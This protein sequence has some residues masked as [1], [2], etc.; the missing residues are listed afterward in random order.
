MAGKQLQTDYTNHQ[1]RFND[2]LN[3]RSGL[4]K[5]YLALSWQIQSF[6]YLARK[7]LVSNVFYP[8]SLRPD[9]MKNF[10]KESRRGYT[11]RTVQDLA[12]NFGITERSMEKILLEWESRLIPHTNVS[13]IKDFIIGFVKYYLAGKGVDF[14]EAEHVAEKVQ[15]YLY[16]WYDNEI[17]PAQ[18]N[19][20]FYDD[21]LPLGMYVEIIFP[22]E[23]FDK[24]GSVERYAKELLPVLKKRIVTSG[25][26]IYFEFGW[27]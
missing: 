3:Q 8:P 25:K 12:G 2:N 20:Y 26:I 10:N 23:H 7:I 19:V 13:G 27:R 17:S 5:F 21:H 14:L 22:R 6:L 9:P 18:D 4:T 1:S 24:I 16:N 15:V 11:E